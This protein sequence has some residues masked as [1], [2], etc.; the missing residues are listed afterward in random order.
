MDTQPLLNIEIRF[1]MAFVVIVSLYVITS[2][3]EMSL[4]Q[5][6][7]SNIVRKVNVQSVVGGVFM[8]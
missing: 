4:V 6:S 5:Q 1:L 8:R 2:S 7:K 3:W